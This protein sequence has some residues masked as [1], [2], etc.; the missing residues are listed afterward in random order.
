ME[1]QLDEVQ[2]AFGNKVC[3]ARLAKRLSKKQLAKQTHMSLSHITAIETGRC[4]VTL[5][6]IRRFSNA[7]NK[8]I[9]YFVPLHLLFYCLEFADCLADVA[10]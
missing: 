7:L 3:K 6:T 5:D 2:Q 9:K 8:P 4:N 1:Q 10:V